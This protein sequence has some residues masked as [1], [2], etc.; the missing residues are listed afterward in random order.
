MVGMAFDGAS[1]F[2]GKHSKSLSTTE[3]VRTT[4]AY[5]GGFRG[6]PPPPPPKWSES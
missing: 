6:L 2:A 3:E 4:W 5:L 1:T